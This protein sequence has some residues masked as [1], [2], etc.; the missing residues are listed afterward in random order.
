M[1]DLTSNLFWYNYTTGKRKS[2]VSIRIF[3]FMHKN[4]V[5]EGKIAF[6]FSCPI[7]S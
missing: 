6:S 2:Q 3:Q 5:S 4:S 1:K 7:I